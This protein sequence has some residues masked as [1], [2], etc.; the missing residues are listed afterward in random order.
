MQMK[1][2]FILP[3]LY[4]GTQNRKLLCVR[5]AFELYFCSNNI[6]HNVNVNKWP[7]PHNLH[8]LQAV[9]FHYRTQAFLNISI[10]LT[11]ANEHVWERLIP[12]NR[13]IIAD[14]VILPC[15]VHNSCSSSMNIIL[16]ADFVIPYIKLMFQICTGLLLSSYVIVL[17]S[18]ILRSVNTGVDSKKKLI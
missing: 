1:V 14:D 4:S 2:V 7:P 13:I 18:I 11:F 12:C 15:W 9:S 6:C 10:F 5:C 8:H 17:K 16:T 3:G